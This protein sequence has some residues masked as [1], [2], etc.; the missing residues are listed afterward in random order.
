MI[1]TRL[2]LY[3]ITEPAGAGGMGEVYCARDE[4]LGWDAAVKVL[5]YNLVGVPS[6]KEKT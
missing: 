4:R 5:P 6:T 2:G 1:E 3:R